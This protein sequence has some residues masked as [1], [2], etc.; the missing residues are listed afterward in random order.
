[1]AVFKKIISTLLGTSAAGLYMILFGLAIG[2]AT[3]VENDF[4][5]SAAQ[6][7]IFKARWF[8]LLLVLFAMSLLY[9]IFKFRMIANKKWSLFLFH[10]S[11]VIIITGAGVTRYMGYE[12]M[13]GIREGSASN[14][15]LSTETYLQFQV[16]DNG[17]KYDF[18]EPVLFASLGNNDF[19]ETYQLG[20]KTLKAEVLQFIP[21]PTEV[22]VEDETTGVPMLKVVVAGRNGREEFLVALGEKVNIYGTNFNFG[23]TP[24]PDAFNIAYENGALTLFQI[25]HTPKW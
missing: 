8:E 3:F 10:I 21:N 6:K 5:T 2:I 24:I 11:M 17:Q 18:S 23:N 4:G 15:F 14:T 7:V 16:V 22:L 12:G 1:M 19:N 13:M 25:A 9:N 20:G